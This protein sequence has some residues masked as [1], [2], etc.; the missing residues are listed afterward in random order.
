VSDDGEL[1]GMHGCVLECYEIGGKSHVKSRSFIALGL[2][3]GYSPLPFN[4]QLPLYR[5]PDR[6]LNKTI[7]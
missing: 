7:G 3:P 4:Y 1:Y 5:F 2:N 6:K